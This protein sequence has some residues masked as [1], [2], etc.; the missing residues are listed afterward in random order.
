MVKVTDY[1]P[2]TP[3]PGPEPVWLKSL[4]CIV[5]GAVGFGAI[6]KYKPEP[7][8]P[9]SGLIDT[10]YAYAY[11]VPAF[12]AIGSFVFGIIF[13]RES[14]HRSIWRHGRIEPVL[15]EG[16]HFVQTGSGAS[17]VVAVA[18][19]SHSPLETMNASAAGMKALRIRGRKVKKIRLRVAN[20]HFDP[21]NIPEA[22]WIITPRGGWMPRLL[23]EVAPAEW[24]KFG[25]PD[26][27]AEELKQQLAT[28]R[29]RKTAGEAETADETRQHL[30]HKYD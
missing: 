17:G 23:A 27:V 13:L 16:L 20:H 9:D 6:L 22:A 7:P 24:S 8:P 29:A 2:K 25:A 1:F 3:R 30:Q 15:V 12:L 26:E 21:N 18:A 10:V 5:V 28:A 11:A 19:S 14:W 4:L